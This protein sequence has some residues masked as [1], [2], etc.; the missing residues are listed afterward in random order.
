MSLEFDIDYLAK[1]SQI[2][3]TEGQKTRFQKEL[4]SFLDFTKCLNRYEISGEE[5]ANAT[6]LPLNSDET[7]QDHQMEK[8]T[9]PVH[10][11]ENAF[12]IPR[13]VKK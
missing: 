5:D 11:K 10:V 1:V 9:D 7:I 3:L 4:E 6:R 13:V 2:K 12:C 8:F